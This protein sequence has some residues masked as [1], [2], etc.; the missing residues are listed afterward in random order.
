MS[1]ERRGRTKLALVAI[2]PARLVKYGD[3]HRRNILEHVFGFRPV[4]NRGVLSK[5]VGHLI[6]DEPA[7][8]RERFVSFL[9]ERA[10][11]F[12]LENAERDPGQDV[13][14]LWN[15]APLQFFRQLRGVA[16]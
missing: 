16:I 8:V 6:D 12:D 13:I 3:E 14:A 10:F 4:E 1:G 9:Q 5:L 2:P 11:L 15:S 7:A